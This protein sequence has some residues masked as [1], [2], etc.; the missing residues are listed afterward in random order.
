[1]VDSNLIDLGYVTS[2]SRAVVVAHLEE[3]LTPIPEV[4]GSNPAIGKI[5][6][7]FVT[8]LKRRK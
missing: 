7:T 6:L 2:L 8:L 5:Y 3:Q 4:R 1:M